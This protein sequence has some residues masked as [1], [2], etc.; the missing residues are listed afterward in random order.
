MT[1][2]SLDHPVLEY[3]ITDDPSKL[4]QQYQNFLNKFHRMICYNTID[5]KNYNIRYFLSCYIYDKAIRKELLRGK[6]HTQRAKQEANKVLQMIRH[7]LRNHNDTEIY[8]ELLLPFLYCA[9]R[10]KQMGVGFNRYI[11]KTYRFVLIRHLNSIK[12]DALDMEP[13]YHTYIMQDTQREEYQEKKPKDIILDERFEL[14]DPRWIHG[15]QSEAPFSLLKPHERYIL[16]K[17]YYEEL[18]DREIARLLP[19][20]P[21]SIHRIRMR[22]IKYLRGLYDKGELRCLRL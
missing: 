14:T 13:S 15:K 17:Y 16:V 18:T 6:Y 11:Y 10:Y 20:N 3:Q 12:W 4:I 9:K 2:L 1:I 8:H 21:K 19:Y 7:K 5:F 22:L